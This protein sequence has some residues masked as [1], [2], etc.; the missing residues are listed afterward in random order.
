MANDRDLPV[1]GEVTADAKAVEVF[2]AWVA[3]GGLVCALRPTQWEDVS[4]W[5]IV[6]ADAARHIANARRDEDG[7]ETPA[8]IAKIREMFNRELNAPTDE[9]TGGFVD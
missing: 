8:T 5:G 2:R 7:V 1:P 9:P 4:A 6:L 3:N